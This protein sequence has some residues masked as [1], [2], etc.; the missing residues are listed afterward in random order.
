M[1]N[2]VVRIETTD[3]RHYLALFNCMDKTGALFVMD[4]LEIIDTNSFDL[5]HDLFLPYV[6]NR[7]ADENTSKVYKY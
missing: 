2:K 4:A 6:I 1:V 7:P 5:D 3:K